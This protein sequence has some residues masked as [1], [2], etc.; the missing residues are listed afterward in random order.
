MIQEELLYHLLKD[1]LRASIWDVSIKS[2]T[3]ELKRTLQNRSV[4]AKESSR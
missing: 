1:I 2:L 4:R 3:S